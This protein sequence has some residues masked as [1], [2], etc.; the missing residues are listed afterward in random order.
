MKKGLFAGTFDPV[1]LGHLDI[2]KRAAAICDILVIGVAENLEKS[3]KTFSLKERIEM[4]QEVTRNL[5][6]VE[7][8]PFSGLV[9]DYVRENKIDYLIRGLRAYTDLGGEF[10]MALTN[11]KIGEVE[12]VFLISGE[13]YSHISSSRIREIGSFGH[14]LHAF[15]PSEIEPAVFERLSAE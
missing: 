7:I 11:R 10:R 4:L 2:I 3:G 1:S 8:I 13:E 12:T 9:V 15:V 5:K 6:T 14:H